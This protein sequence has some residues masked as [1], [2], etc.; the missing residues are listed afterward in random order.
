MDQLLG[1]Y[2]IRSRQAEKL[3]FHYLVDRYKTDNS[4]VSPVVVIKKVNLVLMLKRAFTGL[5]KVGLLTSG[6]VCGHSSEVILFLLG[7]ERTLF[8]YVMLLSIMIGASIT[9]KGKAES[10]SQVEFLMSIYL[11]S[12]KFSFTLFLFTDAIIMAAREAGVR[13]KLFWALLLHLLQVLREHLESEL[14]F[15]TIDLVLNAFDF[16]ESLLHVAIDPLLWLLIW[17]KL[18]HHIDQIIIFSF[19]N[20]H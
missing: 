15:L 4:E 5:G 12:L 7:S 3:H 17:L 11:T 8:C 1:L 6:R 14:L 2:L 18:L 10:Q 9:K 19:S 20:K 13:F 16:I